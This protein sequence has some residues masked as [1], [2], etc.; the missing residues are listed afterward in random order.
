MSRYDWER[1]TIKLPT[2]EFAPLR[3]AIQDIMGKVTS[4][5]FDLTQSFWKGLTRKEQTDRTAYAQ[6]LYKWNLST[7]G[8]TASGHRNPM[9]DRVSLAYDLLD[10]HTDKTGKP[11]R[12]MKSEVDFPTNRTTVFRW[13]EL[14][15]AFDKD[16]HTVTWAV[17]ENNHAVD[18]AHESLLGHEFMLLINKVRWTRQTGGVLFGNDEY[19]SDPDNS[20]I[21]G[22]ANYVTN[23]WGPVGAEQAPRDT[24]PWTDPKG[25]MWKVEIKYSKV[26][27]PTGSKVVKTTSAEVYAE[28]RKAQRFGQ[29]I[30]YGGAIIGY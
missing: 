8:V 30:G 13:G 2:A 14:T 19:H 10:G 12:V 17:R 22:G 28:H 1:G 9:P 15:V 27:L 16:N 20:G 26:G 5:A 18:D 25:Q 4:D 6:A 21:D 23:A 7:V 24:D 29:T 11:V 3:K